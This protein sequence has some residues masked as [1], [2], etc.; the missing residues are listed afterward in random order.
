MFNDVEE[1]YEKMPQSF[2]EHPHDM[3]P[4]NISDVVNTVGWD[5]VMFGSDFPHPEGL[6][7]PDP[8]A[9]DP[10]AFVDA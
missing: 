1:L 5:K 4:R 9:V 8:L 3:F 10:P 7:E 2:P 6:A